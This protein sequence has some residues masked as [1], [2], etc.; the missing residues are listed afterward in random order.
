VAGR[1][2]GPR[3]G[4]ALGVLVL[5]EI[6]TLL[7]AGRPWQ[8]AAQPELDR[9]RDVLAL[10]EPNDLV[11]D[12]QGELLFRKRSYFYPLDGVTQAG[13]AAGTQPDDIPE[14]LAR[15]STCVAA[16][17]DPG[18]PARVRQFLNANYIS[19]GRVRVAGQWLSSTATA[20]FEVQIA[21]L[22]VV[23]DEEGLVAGM[24]DGERCEGARFLEA[25]AHVFR[26]AGVSTNALALVWAQAFERGFSPFA[27]R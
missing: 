11:I 22:Y 23:V 13:P 17:D 3:P 8:N 25:G 6:A 19:V 14:C 15:T 16:P 21:A 2:E 20:T 24:L 4:W 7:L 5:L 26:L 9:I 18:L 12:Q 1:R 27:G 10:T